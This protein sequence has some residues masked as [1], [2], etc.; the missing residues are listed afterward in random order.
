VNYFFGIKNSFLN[1]KLTIPRFQNSNPTKKE[2]ML[3]QLEII[4]QSWKISNLNN[5]DLNSDFYKIG[6][7]LIGNGNI[8]CLATKAEI[9]E[10]EKNNYSK[11]VNFNNFTDTIP[12]YRANLQVSIEGGGFSSYQSDY[13]FSMVTKKGSILSA[14]SSLCNKNADQNIIFFKNIYELPIQEEFCVF[15][16]NIKTMKV[17]KKEVVSTNFLNE[18]IVEKEFIKPEVFL[19][20]DKYIGIPIFCSIQDKHISFEHTHPPHE[21]IMSEDKFK[22]VS[23]L[24]KEF[25]EIIN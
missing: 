3:F 24:K 1:S 5:I 23:E 21:Y 9:L 13:P 8:F 6:S 10:L 2:Y 14:L 7:S 22:L 12:D 17:L 4:N 15:F 18:I 25:S 20:T 19:F 11:L 16:V